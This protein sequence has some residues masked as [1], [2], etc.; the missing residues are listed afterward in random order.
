M[1][2]L[3]EAIDKKLNSDDAHGLISWQNF[4]NDIECADLVESN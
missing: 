3:I 1:V 2:N 4:V